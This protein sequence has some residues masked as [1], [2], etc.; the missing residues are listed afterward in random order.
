M[1]FI[2]SD[3]SETCEV[4]YGVRHGKCTTHFSDGT[5]TNYLYSDGKIIAT[6]DVIYHPEEAFF[7]Q[8]GSENAALSDDWDLY[9]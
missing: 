6:K 1:D 4:R 3:T 5:V 8:D 7:N 2:E 9:I